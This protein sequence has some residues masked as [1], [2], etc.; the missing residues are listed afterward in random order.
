MSTETSDNSNRYIKSIA[1]LQII[2]I[3]LV[4][5][6]HSLHEY[7]DGVMGKT[8]LFYRAFQSFRMPLFLFVSGLLMVY[9]TRVEGKVKITPVR[10]AANK[11]KRLLLPFAVL[12]LVTFFPRAVAGSVADDPYP[13]TFEN[14]IRSFVFQA[15][16][17]VPLFWFLHAS[18]ILLTV[19]FAYLY[20]CRKAGLN[21]RWMALLLCAG[22]M[23]LRL[24]P[25]DLPKF[26]SLRDVQQLGFFFTLG[27]VYGLFLK[28]IDTH[29]PLAKVWF[30]CA[31][32]IVWAVLFV[33]LENTPAAIV[34]SMAGIAMCVSLSKILEARDITFLDHLMGANYIIFLLSWY[35]NVVA[36]QVL[37][38]LITL[39]WWVHTALSLLSG[40]YIPWL[41]YRYLEHHQHS[42]WVKFTAFLLGQS[43]RRK[44]SSPKITG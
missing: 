1:Y 38:H 42:R 33:L 14:F 37:A 27:C 40:I 15:N 29:I 10:F 2:G 30:L 34:C 21:L 3:I 16:M 24:M 44:G 41:A 18:F 25:S 32:G 17:P 31:C 8:T 9:T 4:V 5:A 11:V 19:T 39:P 7:P 13:L 28:W 12:T 23:A 20:V 26:F 36:Q 6:G 43:F 35:C 22:F